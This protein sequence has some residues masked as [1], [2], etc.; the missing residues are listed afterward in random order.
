MKYLEALRV[1][2]RVVAR[3]AP[4]CDRIEIA[5]SLR[6]QREDVHDID[7]VISPRMCKRADL[8]GVETDTEEMLIDDVLDELGEVKKSGP[9]GKQILLPE[10]IHLELWCVRPPAQWGAIFVIRTGNGDFSRWLVT[11]KRFGGAMPS[12]LH[13]KDGCLWNGNT[14]VP[15]PEESDFFAALGLPYIEPAERRAKWNGHAGEEYLE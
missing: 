11:S 7:L 13:E 10:D 12:H 5:G 4:L 6:R 1:A 3:L 14:P 9:R 8:F 15:T 2:N